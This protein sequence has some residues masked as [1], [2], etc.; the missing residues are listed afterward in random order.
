MINPRAQPPAS[1]HKPLANPPPAVQVGTPVLAI[2]DGVVRAAA[3]A[4]ACTGAHV[5]HLFRWNS[6][7]LELDDGRIVEYVHIAKVPIYS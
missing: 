6:V 3:C 7:V 5:A 4:H 2:A 1:T